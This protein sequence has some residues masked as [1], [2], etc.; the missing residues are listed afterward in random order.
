MKTRILPR[1]LALVI[2][3]VMLAGVSS[4]NKETKKGVAERPLNFNVVDVVPNY[5]ADEV[6]YDVTVFFTK[7]IEDEEAI[8][9]FDPEFVNQY[10]VTSSYLGNRKYEYQI[11]SVKRGSGYKVIDMVLDGK[12][13]K[14]D[15]KTTRQLSVYGKDVFKVIDCVVAKENSSA[16][17]IF[18]QQL[19][20]RNIDGFISV[21][22]EMG[23]RT[24]IVGNKI[25]IYFD[26]SNLYRYQ[27]ENVKL[28][29]G[30]GIKDI[31]G[32][33][34][35]DS[36][37][38]NLDLTDL[39]PKVRWSEDGVIVPEVGDATIY[40]D[41]VC[42]NSVILRI[43]RVFDDNIIAYYQENDLDDTYGIRK[44]GRLEKKVKIALESPDPKQWKTFPIVLSDYVDVK[45]GDMYQLILDFGPADYAFA[46]EESKQLT[47]E[48]EELEAK[49]WDGQAYDF[50]DYDYE[51]SWYD[52]LTLTYYND[53]D[54]RK[55]IMVT[56]LAV[57]AKMGADDAAD[58]FVFGIND[59]KPVSGAEV[60][61]YN[62][63][64]QQIA[65]GRTDGDGHVTL[66]C[67]NR[68]A[69]IVASDKQGGQSLIKTNNGESLSYSKFD[70]NGENVEKGISAFAYTNRGVW[71]PGDELQ[72]N[73]MVSDIDAKL[74][75]D[76]P[77]VMEVYDAN[78]RLYSRQSN[79]NPVGGIY[80]YNV[81]TSP[82][83]ETGLW[84]A[85][86]KVGNTVIN[87][88]LRVETVKPNRLEINF[89]T[90]EVISIRNPK[91]AQLNAKWLNGLTASG[92]KAD[93]V[94]KV[95]QGKTSFAKFPTYT[96]CNESEDFYPDE[97]ELFNGPL[98][99]QGNA[100]VSFEPLSDL[101]AD[102]M[103][104]A[105][106]VTT[107]YE[108]TGDFSITS[109]SAKLSPCKRYVGV[110]LPPTESKYGSYY[111]TNRN[112]TFPVALVK[113]DGELSNATS[114]IEYNLYKLDGYWWWSS[115]DSYTLKKYVR[116]TYKNPELSGTMTLNNGK[117]NI[118][119][120][121]PDKKWGSYLLVIKDQQGG[122]TF[123]KVLRF[124]WDYA[125]IHSTGSSD[126]PVQLAMS[127]A[128]DSYNVGEN[129]IVSF[130]ANEKATALVTVEANDKVIY[131]KVMD[132]L[133]TEGQIEI[134]A[135]EEM[136][137]NVYV[138]VSLIQP[139][140][141]ENDL[142][143]RMY[144]VVPVK[145]EDTK[146][147]LKPS[148][149][150]PETSN[151]KKTI[152]VKVS[153]A[154]NQGMTY[155]LAVVDEGI[156]G[157][158]N[159]HTSNPYD[160]FNA[161]Q[162]LKVRT[163]DN[164]K[165]I[166]DA[167]TGELGTVYAIGGDGFVN[168][169]IA[170]DKRFKAYAITLGPFELKAG[171][172]TNT[173]EF[174]VPQC[175]GALRFMVVAKGQG[176]SYGAA[177]KQMKV[178]DPITLYATAPRVTAPGD[179]MTLKVQ[180][181][182]P[183]MKGKTLKVV[184][185]NKNLNAIGELPT[186]VK[187][188]ANGEAMLVMK[189]K[190]PETLGLAT[191][192]VKVSGE[193]YEAQSTT[194]IPIRMPYA[195]KRQ[196]YMKELAPGAT[197]T[198]SF[199]MKGLSGTQE[200]NVMVASLIP[201]DL[202]SRLNYLTTYPYGCL[203]QVV[204]AAF[205]Q[206]YINYFIQQSEEDQ[207]KTRDAIQNGI[208]SIKSYQ[209]ADFSL[210]NWVG[211]TY[212]DPW[213]EL[214]ALHFLVEA[215]NQGFDVPE[216]LLKG[217]MDHQADIAK[218]WAM[219]PDFKQGE[220][221]Q[222]YRLF[223]LALGGAPEMGALNRFKE[224]KMNYNLSSLLTAATY[225]QVGKKNMVSQ[226][227]PAVENTEN[228]SDYISSFGSKTRDLA[229]LTYSEMLCSRDEASIKGHV[230]DLCEILNSGRWLDTQSTAFALFTLGKYAEKIGATN[231]PISAVVNVNGEDHTLT[232]KLGS[233]G[234]PIVPKLGTNQVKVTN[235]SDQ[236]VTA[237][238]YT[239]TAV[240]EYETTENGNFIKMN[241]MYV[242]RNGAAVNPASLP[243]GKAFSAVITVENPSDYRVTELAL[244]Y[245]LASGWEIV[246]DRL[247][248]QGIET[249]G[250]KHLD[251]R[252]DRAYFFFDL[253]PRSKKTFTIKLNATYEGSFMLPAVRCE[254]MYNN[255]IYYVVPA[256]P[257]VVK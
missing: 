252:D 26:K 65:S 211:G 78:S 180:V 99:G 214:Y 146:L 175:S 188:D 80:T 118:Q 209:K 248:E 256:R 37:T 217:L 171:K 227:W 95:R 238:V 22:P 68:P 215:K 53:V 101:Y 6:Q 55:N 161:K 205:P 184:A 172:N 120:N 61:A 64:R 212:S 41:A 196:T 117:S 97:M 116:G 240:A 122:N 71:R 14:S 229:F 58:V 62:Y 219:N 82:N 3:V 123:A 60:T 92:L 230:K 35:S 108:S 242:D 106:F 98:D 234:F 247:F 134:K 31:D 56:D 245:Y 189:V 156:L 141:A 208:A 109:S 86:F 12:P 153:E 19:Q 183:T 185:N 25:V 73:L 63:Q 169:E 18:S 59:A 77:V 75:A 40:F 167:F 115:E 90:P 210:T 66:K 72:L 79:S 24:E 140:N 190:V 159:F 28:T 131:S 51:G 107:V 223:V 216:Y 179:E 170:L 126:G 96:F 105:T 33:S 130:P 204:S 255:D 246:N 187:V 81:A 164:Y 251:I 10:S 199:D 21:T 88:N 57:T 186:S 250:A 194:D 135:T 104:N 133:G 192:D 206:L 87:K 124:D 94:V 38:F 257:V 67:A 198:F 236:K 137:P 182:A 93:I 253:S 16:T 150:I 165:Y 201:V 139:R 103:I 102:Q 249:M 111:F 149:E 226:F 2:S 225:A 36:Q 129:I 45:A 243:M 166:I 237:Q 121:I 154:N 244:S 145:I 47:L 89:N 136:I 8:K 44:A 147:Q 42:L 152:Q 177:E 1:L 151:T 138:Y 83:D 176:K 48:N 32:N 114:A 39:R 70:V 155:T 254:D 11:N 54:I 213:T 160:Y 202:Y 163:W 46:T 128:K 76:Y 221:I 168:Q 52:P 34:L 228:M 112:W 207:N 220:T 113:E 119:I 158:T 178:I 197:E 239:K 222:A 181:L 233:A 191:F 235:N 162:A 20:Q 193:G 143:L 13:I 224:L 7:P 30:A 69:F 110:E 50:K 27:Q 91:N 173:H 84:R 23:Y 29:V 127:S 15:S 5:S 9:I 195:E 132:K 144:G 174:E 231:T 49:Y 148:I 218:A 232:S 125:T 17:L 74:P 85:S 100:S 4:C 200:G 142:P 157:L 203:E 43:V 241:V